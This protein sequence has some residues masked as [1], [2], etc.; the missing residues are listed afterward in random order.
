MN[1]CQRERQ[2][3]E[4]AEL[5]ETGQPTSMHPAAWYNMN[6]LT[7]AQARPTMLCISLGCM[8]DHERSERAKRAHSLLG[9]A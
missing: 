2:A 3:I 1:A 6:K 7:V 5:G 9:R 4:S 8:R